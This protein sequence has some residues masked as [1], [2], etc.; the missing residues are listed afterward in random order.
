MPTPPPQVPENPDPETRIPDPVAGY[1][2]VG[3][4]FGVSEFT[5][6]YHRWRLKARNSDVVEMVAE[7]KS[8]EEALRRD[9]ETAAAGTR[10]SGSQNPD[11]ESR[12]GLFPGWRIIWGFRAERTRNSHARNPKP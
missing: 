4:L 9:A 3:R 8:K 2:R 7:H 12:S 1:F 11:P 5:D 10:K 6:L